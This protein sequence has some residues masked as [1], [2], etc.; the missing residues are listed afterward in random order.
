VKTKYLGINLKA[1]GSGSM[2]KVYSN[3]KLNM[4]SKIRFEYEVINN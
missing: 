3:T 4:R 2:Q 1:K